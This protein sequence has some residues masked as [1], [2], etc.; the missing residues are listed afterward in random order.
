[1]DLKWN[2]ES[3]IFLLMYEGLNG[4]VALRLSAKILALFGYHIIFFSYG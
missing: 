4:V 2:R 1:M 3:E